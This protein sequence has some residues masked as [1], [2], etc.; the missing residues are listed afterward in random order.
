MMLQRWQKG[1]PWSHSPHWRLLLGIL[2]I[3]S[4]PAGAALGGGGT[5]I[6]ASACRPLNGSFLLGIYFVAQPPGRLTSRFPPVLGNSSNKSP[7][8]PHSGL[9]VHSRAASGGGGQVCSLLWA[10]AQGPCK[11][12]LLPS[13]ALSLFPEPLS[14]SLSS[15]CSCLWLQFLCPLP[16]ALSL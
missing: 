12:Q 5:P 2:G 8:T 4:V 14:H 6:L 11:Q 10:P 1:L 9:A 16:R 13:S 7:A 15:F 3:S